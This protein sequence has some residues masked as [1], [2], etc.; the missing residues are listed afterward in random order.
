MKRADEENVTVGAGAPMP[1]VCASNM[2]D[3]CRIRIVEAARSTERQLA[4]EDQCPW[5]RLRQHTL[6]EDEE[7]YWHKFNT[8][9]DL[10]V[11]E[12]RHLRL[13]VA[14]RAHEARIKPAA[15]TD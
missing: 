7:G 4:Y 2:H 5:C 10:V 6:L 9:G 13:A 1:C 15:S 11:C 12:A 14:R 8:T 3:A